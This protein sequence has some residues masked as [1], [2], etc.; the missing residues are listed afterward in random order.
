MSILVDRS[1]SSDDPTH[2]IAF[3]RQHLSFEMIVDVRVKDT[4]QSF[5]NIEF[6]LHA[7]EVISVDLQ[8]ESIHEGTENCVGCLA[9]SHLE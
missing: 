9:V 8:E 3:R 4:Q 5:E 6:K 7:L 2:C 1:E